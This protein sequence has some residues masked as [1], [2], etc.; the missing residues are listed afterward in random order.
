MKTNTLTKQRTWH[1]AIT[2]K[3]RKVKYKRIKFI[4]KRQIPSQF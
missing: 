2:H 1:M 4:F 3:Q